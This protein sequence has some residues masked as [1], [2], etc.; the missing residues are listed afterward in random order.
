VLKKSSWKKNIL[1]EISSIIFCKDFIERLVTDSN[2]LCCA[3]GVIDFKQQ[4]F[5]DGLPSDMCSLSTNCNY[6][7]EFN[8]NQLII[9]KEI[10]EFLRQIFVCN[11]QREYMINH[12]SS[13]LIGS[14][15]NQTISY[16]IGCGA[17]GKSQIIDLMSESLGDYKGIVPV[18]LITQK[19]QSIGG[20][21]SEIAQL[22]G[23]RYAII[24]EPKKGDVINEGIMKEL[25]G[26]DPIQ[27]RMLFKDMITF[28]P[29]FNLAV[30]ANVVMI[31]QSNDEGTWRRIK[32]IKY[33]S[34][35]LN[36]IADNPK[37]Q[38]D[39]DNPYHFIKDTKI[40]NKFP[41]WKDVFLT[42]LIQRVFITKG[43][44]VDTDA[45]S[46]ATRKYRQGQNKYLEYINEN[47]VPNPEGRVDKSVI[48]ADI[49]RWF[50]LNYKYTP[51]NK[52]I[53]DLLN[54]D[55]DYNSNGYIGFTLKNSIE[56][57]EE[58]I[59]KEQEFIEA[60]NKK[61][62]LTQDKEDFIKSVSICE[63]AKSLDLRVSSSKSINEILKNQYGMDTKDNRYYKCK[64]I[65]GKS[66]SCWFAIK[67]KD[68]QLVG[69]KVES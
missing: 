29:K 21:S 46:L 26:G 57:D 34:R 1:N 8:E 9:N 51:K 64:K 37:N 7:P 31:I 23:V 15:D 53:F 19:R 25:T 45:I 43:V 42:K 22:R 47:I 3:N 35:F 16:Y 66:V 60:F 50:E 41:I 62:E 58:I 40:H 69:L 48:G 11:L 61:Y 5:R 18:S 28:K 39:S 65:D 68:P 27:G 17:N 24:Q 12:L 2:L 6:I 54:E 44:V 36:E 52:E 10:D 20:A 59:T 13:S 63:W 49:K 14:P 67:V 56:E 38:Y 4:L 32:L 33:E 30:A 55:Y